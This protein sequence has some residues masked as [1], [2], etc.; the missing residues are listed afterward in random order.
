MKNPQPNLIIRFLRSAHPWLYRLSG[1]RMG[2]RLLDMPVLLLRTVGR[3]TGK[4]RVRALS[5]IYDQGNYLLAASNGGSDF[6]PDW[7]I[8]LRA[9]PK[10][11]IQVGRA[12]LK[13][14][15]HEVDGDERAKLW[16]RFV[17][18]EGRYKIYEERTSRRIPVI[19]LKAEGSED[20]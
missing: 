7:W 18:M 13:V 10:A 5:Y 12:E 17:Q 1:G 9:Q 15:A 16:K 14:T 11:R 4:E 3:K 8:N 20:N 19:I 2:T 6:H